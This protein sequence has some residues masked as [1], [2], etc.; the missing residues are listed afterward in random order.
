MAADDV[1]AA[2]GMKI[3]IDPA[4]GRILPEP[5]Q[6]PSNA[7]VVTP[8]EQNAFSTSSD[9][10][11]ETPVARPGGGYRLNLQ[12]RFQNSLVATVGPDGKPRIVHVSPAPAAPTK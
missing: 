7:L 9:G 11:T 10:L 8:Q 6:G 3:Y 1:A 5:P 2:G 12:G 4:T